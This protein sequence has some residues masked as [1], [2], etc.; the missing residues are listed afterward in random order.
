MCAGRNFV[1]YRKSLMLRLVTV[2]PIFGLAIA[3]PTSTA[4]AQS[5]QVSGNYMLRGCKD[6]AEQRT[7]V[8]DAALTGKCVGV[9]ETLMLLQEVLPAAARFCAPASSNFPQVARIVVKFMEANPQRTHEPLVLLAQ[10]AL[11]KAWPCK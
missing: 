5:D 9:I 10:E 3:S 1:R 6:V 4:T 7:Q 11:N 8:A 2:A